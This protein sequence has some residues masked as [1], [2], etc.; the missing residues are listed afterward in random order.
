MQKKQGKSIEQYIELL[1]GDSD[2]LK[3][4]NEN[5]QYQNLFNIDYKFILGNITI[6]IDGKQWSKS[7]S[8]R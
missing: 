5:A 6:R 3:N 1:E 4:K 2:W 7:G 8:N